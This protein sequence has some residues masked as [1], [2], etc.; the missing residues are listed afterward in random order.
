VWLEILG[1]VSD[2]LSLIGI[3]DTLVDVRGRSA[4]GY[5]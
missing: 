3:L 2:D 4:C 5:Q 1:L